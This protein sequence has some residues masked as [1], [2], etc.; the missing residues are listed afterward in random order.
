V[1][2]VIILAAW[3][4]SGTLAVTLHLA[5]KRRR[6]VELRAEALQAQL[7]SATETFQI[8]IALL[9]VQ[10]GIQSGTIPEPVDPADLP[11]SLESETVER[12]LHDG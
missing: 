1:S 7:L 3:V 8:Q 6:M 12:W 2:V 5:N 11:S 9:Q 4:T 10:S